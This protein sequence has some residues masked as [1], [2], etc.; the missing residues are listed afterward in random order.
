MLHTDEDQK[1]LRRM[2]ISEKVC[3][4]FQRRL[5]SVVPVLKRV[6]F[7]VAS[8][9]ARGGSGQSLLTERSSFPRGH[10]NALVLGEK[11]RLAR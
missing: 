5:T 11:G 6:I 10:G 7:F 9:S 8:P 3:S 1:N 2:L 4:F